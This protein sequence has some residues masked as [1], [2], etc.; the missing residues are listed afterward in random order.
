MKGRNTSSLI[1]RSWDGRLKV[2]SLIRRTKMAQ[3]II[4][5][6]EILSYT[7]P[8]CRVKDCCLVYSL[9][10]YKAC[11]YKLFWVSLGCSRRGTL[12]VVW[13][14]PKCE[15]KNKCSWNLLVLLLLFGKEIC[16]AMSG[17]KKETVFSLPYLIAKILRIAPNV[18]ISCH[19]NYSIWFCR[20]FSVPVWYHWSWSLWHQN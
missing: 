6:Y 11:I 18:V 20:Q 7:C 9:P 2:D 5:C 1:S 14:L 19:L 16:S 15:E 8:T 17:I 3:L 12:S 13:H 4:G 10:M